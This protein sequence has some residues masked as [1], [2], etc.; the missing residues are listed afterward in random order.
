MAITLH[1]TRHGFN[2]TWRKRY[3]RGERLGR[4]VRTSR[5]RLVEWK[6]PGRGEETADLELYDYESDP[7]ETRNLAPERPAVVARIRAMLAKLLEAKPQIR[8]R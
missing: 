5:Y 1:S 3:P 4:A 7:L 6:V 8:R 2:G